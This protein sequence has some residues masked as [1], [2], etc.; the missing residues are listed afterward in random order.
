MFSVKRFLASVS[1]A[2][3][4]AST[5]AINISAASYQFRGDVNGD[6]NVNKE[7]VTV[8]KDYLSRKRKNGIILQASDLDKNGKL[9]SHDLTVLQRII[10]SY[11]KQTLFIKGGAKEFKPGETFLEN[12]KYMG[13]MQHDGNVV[14]YRKSD[15]A[16][17]FHT[18]TH[19]GD[20]FKDYV[21]RFQADGNIVLYATPNYPTA[22]RRA[23]WNSQTCNRYGDRTKPYELSFD[24]KG[25]LLFNGQNGLLWSSTYRRIAPSP[26]TSLEKRWVAEERMK[27]HYKYSDLDQAAIDFIFY[28]NPFSIE[29]RT[30]YGA[31]IEKITDSN[32]NIKYEINID[33]DNL[34]PYKGVQRGEDQPDGIGPTMYFSENTVAY[35]HT[36]GHYVCEANN[37]FSIYDYSGDNITDISTAYEMNCIAY[38][39]APNGDIR[40]FDPNYDVWT[41]VQS[42]TGRV[43]YQNAPVN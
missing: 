2:A 26:L 34:A 8:L 24:N 38:L 6:N 42:T 23:I 28:F 30:E 25:N 22:S 12:D 17:L 19:F 16:A 3:I 33:M 5:F 7:D 41:G 36:H 14:V 11:D 13:V 39:G 40:V 43:I 15:C 9:D 1:V 37:Y 21:L 31:T 29:Q 18:G 20:E 27:N 32:G 10:L 4:M 35:V